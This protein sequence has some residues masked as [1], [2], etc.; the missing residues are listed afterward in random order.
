MFQ[1][2]AAFSNQ[3][4]KT[5]HMLSCVGLIVPSLAGLCKLHKNSELQSQHSCQ[6]NRNVVSGTCLS[7]FRSFLVQYLAFSLFQ[8]CQLQELQCHT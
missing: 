5:D 6:Q 7:V 3:S 8:F 4:G 2:T 1:A